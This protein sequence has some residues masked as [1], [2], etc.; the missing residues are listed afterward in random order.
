M[1]RLGKRVVLGFGAR[2]QNA[3]S[4]RHGRHIAF[5]SCERPLVDSAHLL[6]HLSDDEVTERATKTVMRGASE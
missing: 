1:R 3:G 5:V 6:A 4:E 2:T